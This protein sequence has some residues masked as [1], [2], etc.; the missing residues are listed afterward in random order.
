V[1]RVAIVQDAPVFLDSRQ[2]T[3]RIVQWIELAAERGVQLIAF[4]ET[5]LPGYPF[6]LALTDGARFDEPAQKEA[7]RAYLDAAVE[8]TGPELAE[9]T[10]AARRRRVSVI[11]GIAE[12]VG[13]SIY[14]SAVTIDPRRGLMPPHRKL[15]PTYEERLVWA[16][17][18]GH[19][20]RTHDVAGARAGVLCCWENWMPQARHALYAD[21][22]QVHVALW[23]GSVRNTEHVTRFVAL[24]GRSFVISASSVLQLVDIPAAFPL[25]DR[26]PQ[27]AGRYFH[28]GGSA[29]A[30][31]DGA[32][33]V[34]PVRCDRTFIVADLDLAAVA[35]E[36]HNFDPVG[37]Y[38]RADVFRVEV[39]RTRRRAAEFRD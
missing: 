35:R 12:R 30:G 36:R 34:P 21:G 16:Q 6:W 19:G 5:Y 3:A 31:P 33:I 14:C 11:L 1:L 39:D 38:S 23:P 27:D 37:H 26:L 25:R 8:L 10:A 17:G 4:G 15:M 32:W 28:D 24:E 2:T 22:M 7:Y 20:L 18:D 9:I 29:I 13:A